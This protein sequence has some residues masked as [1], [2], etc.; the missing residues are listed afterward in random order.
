MST[1]SFSFLSYSVLT[2]EIFWP[3][4]V[5]SQ[6][7]AKY[8]HLDMSHVQGTLPHTA[9]GFSGPGESRNPAHTV[10]GLAS[11][12]FVQ[13]LKNLHSLLSSGF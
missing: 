3:P 4:N 7:D 8:F 13:P 9:N 6:A 10:V 11:S 2:K 1:L 12:T 5:S